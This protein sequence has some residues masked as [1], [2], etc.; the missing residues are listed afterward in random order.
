MSFNSVLM[1]N[2]SRVSVSEYAHHAVFTRCHILAFKEHAR[3]GG[4]D[5]IDIVLGIVVRSICSCRRNFQTP[6]PLHQHRC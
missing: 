6:Q 1:V 5:L 2:E 4:H 3:K